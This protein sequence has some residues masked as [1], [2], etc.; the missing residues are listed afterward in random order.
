[1]RY[2]HAI[3][4]ALLTFVCSLAPATAEDGRSYPMVTEGRERLYLFRIQ[5]EDE[6]K[7]NV[8]TA[9]ARL[10]PFVTGCGDIGFEDATDDFWVRCAP[11]PDVDLKALGAFLRSIDNY[12]VDTGLVNVDLMLIE[13]AAVNASEEDRRI[14]TRFEVVSDVVE[15]RDPVAHAQGLA[16]EEIQK[17]V[18]A[19]ESGGIS[20]SKLQTAEA[21]LRAKSPWNNADRGTARGVSGGWVYLWSMCLEKQRGLLATPGRTPDAV[22]DAMFFACSNFEAEA[23]D[24]MVLMLGDGIARPKA[25]PEMEKQFA[26]YRKNMRTNSVA[27]LTQK[28]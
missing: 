16:N 4:A 19:F 26:E 18:K 3:A 5:F 24:A 13:P 25:M 9:A 21:T 22:V 7:A 23:R 14:A 2:C 6:R 10:A 27:R 11:K 1:M 17:A 28:N 12:E 15:L 20:V 8:Q